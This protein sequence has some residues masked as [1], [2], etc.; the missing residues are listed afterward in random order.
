[1]VRTSVGY[2]GG[3]SPAPTYDSVCRGDGHTE[4]LRVWYDPE[5][6]SYED[7]L[8]FYWKHYVGSTFFQQYKAA[9]WY[10]DEEQRAV[11]E[12][13]V[14]EEAKV[15]SRKPMVEILPAKE[16]YDAEDYHQKYM[17]KSKLRRA[18]AGLPPCYPSFR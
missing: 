10:H 5:Q 1:V 15:K 18:K 17:W 13:S 7:L 12:A 4:A 6:T 8:K 14:E 11:A 9:I 3:A 2:T 16:W